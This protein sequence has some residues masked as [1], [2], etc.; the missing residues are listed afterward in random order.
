M[1]CLLVKNDIRFTGYE[2]IVE[3]GQCKVS[4]TTF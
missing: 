1:Y 2:V 3:R 4:I